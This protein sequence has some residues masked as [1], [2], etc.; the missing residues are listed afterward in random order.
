MENIVR[1][2]PGAIEMCLIKLQQKIA[3]YKAQPTRRESLDSN[4]RPA[5]P[6]VAKPLSSPDRQR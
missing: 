4:E 2:Q 1:N 5:S 3:A 6:V